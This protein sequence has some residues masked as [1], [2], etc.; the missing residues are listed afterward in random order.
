[1]KNQRKIGW[2][3]Q[4]KVVDLLYRMTTPSYWEDAP[5]YY[6]SVKGFIITEDIVKQ[7]LYLFT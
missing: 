2:Q 6:T 7:V 5:K 4:P 3:Q 1:M